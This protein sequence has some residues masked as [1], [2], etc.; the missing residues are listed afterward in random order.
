V[1]GARQVWS[2]SASRLSTLGIAAG[3]CMVDIM[4]TFRITILRRCAGR[5]TNSYYNFWRSSLCD[6]TQ[7]ETR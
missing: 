6:T 7:P 2:I 4:G 5:V 3:F 1:L